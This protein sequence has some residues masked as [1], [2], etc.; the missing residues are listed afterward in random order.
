MELE[1]MAEPLWEVEGQL[2][3][4]TEAAGR[5]RP[6]LDDEPEDWASDY[7]IWTAEDPVWVDAYEL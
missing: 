3:G 4:W 2:D 5:R 7:P 1:E 6:E